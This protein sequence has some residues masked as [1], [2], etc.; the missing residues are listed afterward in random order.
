MDV[1]IT[2][3]TDDWHSI[4]SREMIGIYSTKRKAMQ[5]IKKDAKM[6]DEELEDDDICMLNNYN[7]T[8]SRNAGNEYEIEQIT[9]N[10]R[11]IL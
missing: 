8:Q 11:L 7:Q 4:A 6:Q 2:Y 1:F 10:N 3:R 5:A 9:L